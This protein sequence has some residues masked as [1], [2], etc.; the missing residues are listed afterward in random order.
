M[1]DVSR[2][3]SAISFTFAA[4]ATATP[5]WPRYSLAY[6][7]ARWDHEQP[8]QDLLELRLPRVRMMVRHVVLVDQQQVWRGRHTW[9]VIAEVFLGKR[10]GW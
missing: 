7:G 6:S 8:S 2:S 1:R 10:H 3:Q 5:F 9:N 4:V